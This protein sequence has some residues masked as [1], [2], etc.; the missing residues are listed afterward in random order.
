MGRE[1]R[2]QWSFVAVALATACAS[3]LASDGA[4]K[5]CDPDHRCAEGF[6]C[7]LTTNRCV[8][9]GSAGGGGA[10]AGQPGADASSGGEDSAAVKDSATKDGAV[11]VTFDA[12]CDSPITYFQDSDGDGFGRDD[13]AKP[14]CNDPGPGWSEFGGDCADDEANAFPGQETYFDAGY[15]IGGSKVSFDFDCD[16]IESGD[17]TQFNA[18]PS[19][20]GLDLGNCD[21]KGFAPTARTEDGANPVCGSTT[22]IECKSQQL[23]CTAQ[24]A[25][26]AQPKR[27]R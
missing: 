26:T 6:V 4:G 24:A 7:E 10:D 27:C 11:D 19:C 17:P 2:T 16:D 12:N 18:A 9:E 20:G 8:V 3:D 21:G 14:A 15:A 13:V 22:L 1:R 5:A 23:S 25:G